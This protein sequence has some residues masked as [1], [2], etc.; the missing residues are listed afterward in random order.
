ME[1]ASES[2]SALSARVRE[3]LL[4]GTWIA[5]TNW[6]DQLEKTPWEMALQQSSASK[7]SVY[8]LAFHVHYYVEGILHFFSNGQLTI[9]DPHSFDAPALD[10]P[11]AWDRFRERFRRNGEAIAQRIEGFDEAQLSAV[12]VDPR[13]GDY[14]RNIEGLIEHAYYHL[15]QVALIRNMLAPTA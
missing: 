6:S 5:N 8:R 2:A 9:S 7:N 11:E 12:F 1:N 15:G 3:V 4:D 10:G 13:Y 14:R